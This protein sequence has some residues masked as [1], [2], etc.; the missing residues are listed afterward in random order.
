MITGIPSSHA[1]HFD[2]QSKDAHL[3]TSSLACAATAF[4][5]GRVTFL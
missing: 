4:R 5:R 2:R 3:F 1:I